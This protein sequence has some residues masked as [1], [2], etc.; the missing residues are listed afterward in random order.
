MR[1]RT[2]SVLGTT[3][4]ADW[5]VQPL[6]LTHPFTLSRGSRSVIPN[7]AVRLESDGAVGCGEA[8]PN[9]RYGESAERVEQ[10]LG[11]AELRLA[12]EVVE[13]GVPEVVHGEEVFGA[14]WTP[15]RQPAVLEAV[16]WACGRLDIPTQYS[17][18]L[19]LEAAWLELQAVKAGRPLWR[20]L[21]AARPCTGSSSYTIGLDT[22]ERMALKAAE[23]PGA[24]VFKVKLGMGREEDMRIMRTL[25][26]ITERPIRVDANEGWT[27]MAE[28]ETMIR[29]LSE[30]GVELVEQPMP[31]DRVREMAELREWSPLPLIADESFAGESGGGLDGLGGGFHGVNI[32]LM[33]TGSV[34]LARRILMEAKEAGLKVMSGCMIESSLGI[35]AGALI[36]AEA[37]FVDLDGH[38]LI[39]EDPWTGLDTDSAGKV[40]LNAEAPGLGVSPRHEWKGGSNSEG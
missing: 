18:A 4:Q 3:C 17:A 23:R 16:R 9:P 1:E 10:L 39:R 28:A 25:R 7:V 29:F 19:A 34:L 36:G 15:D 20:M 12:L 37:D 14:G 33:K 38:L 21:G 6:A 24:E 2:L 26:E 40:C 11:S 30:M 22:P 27:E 13:G 32:K 5:R 31:A 35:A 8:G